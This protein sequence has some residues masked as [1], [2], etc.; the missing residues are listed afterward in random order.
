MT[1]S[2]GSPHSATLLLREDGT[3][4]G[5]TG[6]RRFKASWEG[7]PDQVTVTSF[8]ASGSCEGD[9]VQD[10]HV[11]AVLSEGFT[12]EIREQAL[13]LYPLQGDTD[14]GLTYTTGLR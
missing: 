10:A 7:G 2:V 3:M 12:Y 4:V 5:T 13:D 6:C 11:I 9:A 1:A 14:T 8:E